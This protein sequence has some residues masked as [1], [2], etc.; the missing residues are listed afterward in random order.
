MLIDWTDTALV[1]LGPLQLLR[2]NASA[3]DPL[4]TLHGPAL[5]N[6][7]T[8]SY[9]LTHLLSL[10]LAQPRGPAHRLAV[11]LIL[12]YLLVQGSNGAIVETG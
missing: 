12:R 8:D 5:E 3:E 4:Q 6:S 7:L 1:L 10:L 11:A 2:V 9:L